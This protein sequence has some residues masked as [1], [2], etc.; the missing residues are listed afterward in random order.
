MN[1]P[2]DQLIAAIGTHLALRLVSERGGTRVYVPTLSRL[3]DDCPLARMVGTPAAA[4]LA[5]KWPGEWIGV[6]LAKA[7]AR[8]ARDREICRRYESDETAAALARAFET[9]ERNI[10]LIV[11]AG[12]QDEAADDHS[13]PSPQLGL[14]G[15]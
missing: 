4:K 14:F 12:A 3:T 8:R 15:S 1:A 5:A 10:H 2:L 13:K 7:Y 6:P 9:S 11:V